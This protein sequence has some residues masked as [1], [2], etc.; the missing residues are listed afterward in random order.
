MLQLTVLLANNSLSV[1]D[2]R[3]EGRSDGAEVQVSSQL[4]LPGHRS[5]VRALDFSSDGTA[6]LSASSEQLK[7]WNRSDSPRYNVLLFRFLGLV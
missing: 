6:L 7:V 3:L 1:Y 5:E 2:V 4:L